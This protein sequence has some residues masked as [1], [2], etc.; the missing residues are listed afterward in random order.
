[1]QTL[2]AII[3]DEPE[4]LAGLNPMAPA[5]LSVIVNRCLAKDL[6]ER[7]DSTRDLARDIEFVTDVPARTLTAPVKLKSE[8]SIVSI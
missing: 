1:M 5:H 6:L 4:P 3:E 7:Y 2:A 8:Q